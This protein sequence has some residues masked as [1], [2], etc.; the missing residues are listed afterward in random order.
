MSWPH[1]VMLTGEIS[2]CT[3]ISELFD[4]AETCIRTSRLLG[5]I[6]PDEAAN[7]T[8]HAQHALRQVA[9]VRAAERAS[10]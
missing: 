4:I 2:G 8:E 9:R 3:D 10:A 5:N 1:H 7:Y 6:E